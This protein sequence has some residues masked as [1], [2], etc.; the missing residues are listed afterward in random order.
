ME[1]VCL[2][3]VE[4]LKL[5]RSSLDQRLQISLYEVISKTDVRVSSH[6]KRSPRTAIESVVICGPGLAKTRLAVAAERL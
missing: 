2:E 1:L 3:I 6:V 4:L 5:L